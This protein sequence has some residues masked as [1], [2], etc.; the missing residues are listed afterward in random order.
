MKKPKVGIYNITGCCGC[1]LSVLFN[2]DEILKLVNIID[3][4]AFPFI[5]KKQVSKFD[6]ILLEGTV[7]SKDDLEILNELRT[8]TKVLVALGACACTGG[9]PS[10]KNF[11]NPKKYQQL[12]FPKAIRIQDLE[13]KPIDSYVKVDYYLPGCPP[14]EK[15]ILEFCKQIVI[16]KKPEL[17]DKPVCLE[18]RMHENECLLDIGKLCLGPITRGG[19]GS[20]CTNSRLECWGCRGPT[21]DANYEELLKLL[22]D[23]GFDTR[24]IKKRMKT[25]VGLKLKENEQSH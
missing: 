17:Y 18:C 8:K 4:K 1:V 6:I 11:T 10:F 13:P 21:T 22:R 23:K 5:K 24:Y 12:M 2:E 25:F 19:C 14:D 7:V 15:E 3:V 9:I 16:G 20:V